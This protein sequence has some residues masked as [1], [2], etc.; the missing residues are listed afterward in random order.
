MEEHC[1]HRSSSQP[2]SDDSKCRAASEQSYREIDELAAD[3]A[4]AGAQCHAHADLAAT[5]SHG[6]AQ[7]PIT[8]DGGEQQRYP[9][10][11]RG[12]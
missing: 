1:L 3:L 5:L 8:P 9:G 12:Q 11:E 7:H 2:C 10:E 6:V 4:W